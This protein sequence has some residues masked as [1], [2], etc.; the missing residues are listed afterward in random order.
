MSACEWVI[1]CLHVCVCER[2][3]GKEN[4]GKVMRGMEGENAHV[5]ASSVRLQP[6]ISYPPAPKDGEFLSPCSSSA[7]TCGT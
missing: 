1:L 5:P 7:L 4:K 6:I 3:R 2:E